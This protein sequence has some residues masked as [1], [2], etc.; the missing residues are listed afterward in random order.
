M[1]PSSSMQANEAEIMQT[2]KKVTVDELALLD[3]DL[4]KV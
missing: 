4:Y 3:P 1:L 2:T